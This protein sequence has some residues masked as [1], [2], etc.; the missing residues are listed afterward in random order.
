MSVE[1]SLKWMGPIPCLQYIVREAASFYY[2][3]ECTMLL[4]R[5]L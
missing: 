4:G 5:S 3:T 1:A 2:Y